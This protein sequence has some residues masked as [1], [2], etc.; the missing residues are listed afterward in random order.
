VDLE[1]L[2]VSCL[3]LLACLFLLA[4]SAAS[5]ECTPAVY[6]FRHA[7]DS[8]EE[9]KPFPCLPG[10]S[11]KCTTSLT[12]V[13][14]EHADLYVEMITSLE[15]KEEL[16]PVK[17]VYSVNPI[18]PDGHGGT[19]NPFFTAKPLANELMD[20]DPIVEIS[21]EILDQKLTVASPQILHDILIAIAK[22][23]ASAALFWTSEGLH[24]LG[25]ALGTDIIPKKTPSVSPPRNAAYIFRYNGGNDF[26][27]PPK[28]DQYV[29]CFN[30]AVG[31]KP[32]K[33]FTNRFYCGYGPNG[34]LSVPESDF[35]QLH[36]RICSPDAPDFK[37]KAPANYYG[38][39]ESPST[40]SP[41]KE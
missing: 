23:G 37:K 31:G 40:V 8:K 14:K 19:T 5:S 32:E 16:C 34:N 38:Y 13:G 28:A 9:V 17:A 30:Y 33:N 11:V 4:S 20:L 27:P 36:G 6:A 22:S 25:E 39:C 2:S 18:N 35:D 15:A 1:G 3:S 21:G 7:E 12:D 29:Q 24:D 26:S 10:S 41:G